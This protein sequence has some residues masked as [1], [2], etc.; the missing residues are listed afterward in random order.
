MN[1]NDYQKQITQFAIYPGAGLGGFEEVNYLV[2]GLTSEAGELAGKWKKFLRDGDFDQEKFLAEAGDVLWYL[3]Q[4][5]SSAQVSLETLAERNYNKLAE[6]LKTNTIRGNGDDRE[7][8]S[9][10]IINS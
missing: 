3:T 6:R 5:C 10:L 2:L 4:L 8:G 7:K 9:L 1:I